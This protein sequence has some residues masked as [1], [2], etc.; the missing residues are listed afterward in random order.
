MKMEENFNKL[1]PAETERLVLLAE[2][3]AESIQAVGKILRHGWNVIDPNTGIKY[4]NRFDLEKE[5]AQAQ[6]ALSLMLINGDL[7]QDNIANHFSDKASTI[8]QY[9]HHNSVPEEML[10]I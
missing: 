6:F 10:N 1:T 2:E 4:Y 3:L 9:L 7:N 8:Q 5:L